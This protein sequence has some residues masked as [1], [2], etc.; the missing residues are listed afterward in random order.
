M[1]HL[2]QER[3]RFR[4]KGVDRKEEKRGKGTKSYYVKRGW[5]EKEREEERNHL[6]CA[7]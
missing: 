1:T 4:T 3:G 5:K 7:Y 6:V 2:F